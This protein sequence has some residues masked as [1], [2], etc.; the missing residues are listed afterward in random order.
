MS[1][2]VMNVP[3]PL[4]GSSPPPIDAYWL[5]RG[6]TP[7]G[8]SVLGATLTVTSDVVKLLVEQGWTVSTWVTP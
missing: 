8:T 6:A 2:A 5:G 1:R 4:Q 7:L 3:T